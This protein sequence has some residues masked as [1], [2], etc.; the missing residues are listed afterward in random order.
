[1]QSRVS[2]FIIHLEIQCHSESCKLFS[3]ILKVRVQVLCRDLLGSTEATCKVRLEKVENMSFLMSKKEWGHEEE[4]K[5]EHVAT[6]R[7][8]LL[9]DRRSQK[10]YGFTAHPLHA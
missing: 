5:R 2:I 3:R 9:E 10:S 4:E 6:Q 8:K 1:M 7:K